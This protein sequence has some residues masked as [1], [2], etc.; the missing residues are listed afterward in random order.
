MK[1]SM[2]LWW[3]NT[4]RGK[5]KDRWK[6]LCLHI[7]RLMVYCLRHGTALKP[8]VHQNNIYNPSSYLT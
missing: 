2:E 6:N 5:L 3:N 1:M 8:E 7:E 4:D